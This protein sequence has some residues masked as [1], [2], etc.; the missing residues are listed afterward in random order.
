MQHTLSRHVLEPVYFTSGTF[1]NE[2]R[3]KSS[4]WRSLGFIKVNP[5]L[6]G[7]AGHKECNIDPSECSHDN[8]HNNKNLPRTGMAGCAPTK[9]RDCHS[10]LTTILKELVFAA[11]SKSGFSWFFDHVQLFELLILMCN[12]TASDIFATQ[13]VH[14][15]DKFTPM[16]METQCSWRLTKGSSTERKV[17]EQNLSNFI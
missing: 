7:S 11:N 2:T 9:L 16:F 3:R 17:M 1:N 14:M 13:N 15:F 5:C 4:A 12:W 10:M 8:T 6:K